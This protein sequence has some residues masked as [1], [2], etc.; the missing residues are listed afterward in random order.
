MQQKLMEP[1]AEIDKS[2]SRVSDFNSI[3]K[4]NDRKTTSTR[5]EI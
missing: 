1:R 4:M 3:F 5:K 2:T